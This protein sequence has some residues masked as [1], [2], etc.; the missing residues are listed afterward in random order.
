MVGMEITCKIFHYS[1][2]T[3]ATYMKK[4]LFTLALIFCISPI[5]AKSYSEYLA[6]AKKYEAQKKWCYALG[7]YYDAMGT[8]EKPEDKQEAYEGYKALSEA[9]KSGNPGLV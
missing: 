2:F 4:L 5:F 7:S 6:E 3:E 1:F 8:D 9:I